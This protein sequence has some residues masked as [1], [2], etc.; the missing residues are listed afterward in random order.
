MY[1]AIKSLSYLFYERSLLYAKDTPLFQWM[2]QRYLQHAL[3]ED[4]ETQSRVLSRDSILLFFLSQPVEVSGEVKTKR[5]RTAM[6]GDGAD[7]QESPVGIP[8]DRE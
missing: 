8:G 5:R 3:R 4:P 6:L 1:Q 7:L 2:K